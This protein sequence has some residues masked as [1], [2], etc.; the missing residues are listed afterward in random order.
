MSEEVFSNRILPIRKKVMSAA[1]LPVESQP[2]EATMLETITWLNWRQ[3]SENERLG[4]HG[5]D[6]IDNA[7]IAISGHFTYVLGDGYLERYNHSSER[8]DRQGC[9]KLEFIEE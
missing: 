9:Y 2:T 4:F 6:D 3:L 7:R 8:F 5:I 1:S